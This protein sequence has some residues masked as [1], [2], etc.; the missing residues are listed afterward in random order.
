MDRIDWIPI[1][2]L[3]ETIVEIASHAASKPTDELGVFHLVHPHATTWSTLRPWVHNSLEDITQRPIK[4]VPAREWIDLVKKDMESGVGTGR[5]EVSSEKLANMLN[6][7]PAAKL[8]D[9]YPGILGLKED[10]DEN[11]AVILETVKTQERS[12]RLKS[13]EVLKEKWIWKWIQ[14]WITNM[15]VSP[16]K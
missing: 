1:D 15:D 3:A 4:I 12:E 6:K 14:E 5:A 7:N 10:D 13:L 8:I 16:Q 9:F 11:M 2:K